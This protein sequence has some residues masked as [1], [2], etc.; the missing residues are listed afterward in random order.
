MHARRAKRLERGNYTGPGQRRPGC[1]YPECV[2]T[3]PGRTDND[4]Q[5]HSHPRR[6]GPA[7]LAQPRPRRRAC[8]RPAQQE[9]LVAPARPARRAHGRRRRQKKKPPAGCAEAL[10][11]APRVGARGGVGFA[12]LGLPSESPCSPPT[13]AFRL[14]GRA[15]FRL[16]EQARALLRG[17]ARPHRQRGQ[18]RRARLPHAAGPQLGG[19]LLDEGRRAGAGALPG[20]ARLRAHRARQ[21][22]VRHGGARA[23]AHRRAG[24]ARVP[25]PH[26]LRFGL[27]AA[28]SWCR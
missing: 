11:N 13:P 7:G 27:A 24:R 16:A 19:L 21:G 26:R 25:R 23:A 6:R 9:S 14:E 17:R 8:P 2:C 1:R 20:Q 18:P 4:A 10:P 5:A 3:M 22:R 15:P 28:R 12:K